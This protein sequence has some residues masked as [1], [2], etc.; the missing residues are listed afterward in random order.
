MDL[1]FLSAVDEKDAL[2]RETAHPIHDELSPYHDGDFRRA[3]ASTDVGDVSWICPT[4]QA[5]T[6]TFVSGTPGHS[7][8]ATTVGKTTAAHKM[9]LYA[10]KSMAALAVEL[11]RDE[12]LLAK[13]KAEHKKRV[14]PNGYRCPIPAG[15]KPRAMNGFSKKE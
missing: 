9:M 8:Q 5:H 15:V 4:A 7:W 10:A 11:I 13:A 12:A 2:L 6:A 14:G 1:E 3:N